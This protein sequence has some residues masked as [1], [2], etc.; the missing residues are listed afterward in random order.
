MTKFNEILELLDEINK[1]MPDLNFGE[2]IQNSVDYNK[3]ENNTNINISN[4][5]ILD[6]I[7]NYF[8]REKRKRGI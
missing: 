3:K 1:L 4:K 2:I 8:E 6:S 5:L 7:N